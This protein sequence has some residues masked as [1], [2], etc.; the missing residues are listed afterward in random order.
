MATERVRK[1]LKDGETA[2]FG[3]LGLLSS[4]RRLRGDF[5]AFYKNCQGSEILKKV[6]KSPLQQGQAAQERWLGPEAGKFWVTDA[7]CGV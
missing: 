6:L 3:E 5:T 4:S 1:L 7:A 2:S